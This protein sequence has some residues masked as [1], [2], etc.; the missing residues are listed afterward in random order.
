MPN[1]NTKGISVQIDR[2]LHAE[3]TAYLQERNMKMADFITLAAQELLRPPSMEM[4]PV[5]QADIE[6]NE[7]INY[8]SARIW[9][10]TT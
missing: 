10:S 1:Q 8:P 7:G 4:D 5:F 6:Y 3:I 2:E 9:S